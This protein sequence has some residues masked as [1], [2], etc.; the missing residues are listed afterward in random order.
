MQSHFQG[1][2]L[3]LDAAHRKELNHSPIAFQWEITPGMVVQ[4]FSDIVN[5]VLE[6]VFGENKADSRPR[7]TES[8]TLKAI[9]AFATLA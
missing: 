4:P 6:A 5:T 3:S 2:T 1:Y 9:N 8:T 7:P